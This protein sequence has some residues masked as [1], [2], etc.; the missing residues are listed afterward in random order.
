MYSAVDVADYIVVFYSCFNLNTQNQ[1][2]K[3]GISP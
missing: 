3:P 1:Q 2:Q